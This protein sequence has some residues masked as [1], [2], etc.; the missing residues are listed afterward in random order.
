MKIAVTYD[1]GSVF[2]HFGKTENFKIFEV[3]NGAI[4]SSEVVGSNG[5]GHHLQPGLY[6]SA[7]YFQ[8]IHRKVFRRF[9][10]QHTF[11]R[12]LRRSEEHTS[13]LQS[14]GLSR[15]PSSA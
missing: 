13:E 2:Q 3:E 4:I 10:P 6:S 5:A 7:V 9:L 1:N 12:N 15:M 11:C 14:R 8:K